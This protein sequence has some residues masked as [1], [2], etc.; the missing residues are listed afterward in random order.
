MSK[1][2]P[3]CGAVVDPSMS[4]CKKCGAPN[5]SY[6]PPGTSQLG[7]NLNVNLGTAEPWGFEAPVRDFGNRLAGSMGLAH[8]GSSP[9]FL[10]L[11]VR[12]AFLDGDAYRAAAA[13]TNGTKPALLALAIPEIAGLIG[14][15]LAG[16]RY[17]LFEFSYTRLVLLAIMGFVV[18]IGAVAVMAALSAPVLHRKLSFGEMLRGLAYA[19]SP[20]ALAVIPVLGTILSFWRLVTSLVAIRELSG[21]NVVKSAILLVIGVVAASLISGAL[22]PLLLGSFFL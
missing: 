2:C 22:S 8:A 19:Q 17:S 5:E 3:F 12:G 20:G 6:V 21:A 7:V 13:D 11:L 16:S 10:E 18:L 1:N 15:L 14:G 4:E 9:G